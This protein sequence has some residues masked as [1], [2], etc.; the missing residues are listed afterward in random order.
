MSLPSLNQSNPSFLTT[1]YN[2]PVAASI[3]FLNDMYADVG[4]NGVRAQV[5]HTSEM[6]EE[7]GFF[8]LRKGYNRLFLKKDDVISLRCVT[9]D[10]RSIDMCRF[11]V[12]LASDLNEVKTGGV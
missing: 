8:V 7:K 11:K 12:D 3:L 6:I 1:Q 5:I 2:L 10:G 9:I 4:I